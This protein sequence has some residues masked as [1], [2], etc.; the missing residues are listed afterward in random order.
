MRLS[1]DLLG[2]LFPAAAGLATRAKGAAADGTDISDLLASMLAGAAHL[3]HAP[4]RPLAPTVPSLDLTGGPHP[5]SDR[6]GK[7][8]EADEGDAAITV[9]AAAAVLA[10][11]AAPTPA[12]EP[13]IAPASPTRQTGVPEGEGGERLEVLEVLDPLFSAAETTPATAEATPVV[14]NDPA[15][16]DATIATRPDVPALGIESVVKPPA[17]AAALPLPSTIQPPV[18]GTPST[19]PSHASAADVPAPEAAE[20]ALRPAVTRATSGALRSE[21]T[22]GEP[23]DTARFDRPGTA[24]TRPQVNKPDA[25]QVRAASPVSASMSMDARGAGAELERAS[26][27]TAAPTVPST[28]TPDSTPTSDGST[29]VAPVVA[30][31]AGASSGTP[32]QPGGTGAAID[33]PLEWT[34]EPAGAAEL[35]SR[36]VEA[37]NVQLRAGGGTAEIRLTP[38][39][40]GAVHVTVTVDRGT[41]KASVSAETAAGLEVLRAEVGGLRDALEAHGLHLD[42]FEIREDPWADRRFD[43]RQQDEPRRQAPEPPAKRATGSGDFADVFDVVA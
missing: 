3:P 23:A 6:D 18:T 31:H 29:F 26:H 39:F 33:A 41:V 20:A 21:R 28:P 11:M 2:E 32:A 34:A 9:S 15:L 38:A 22:A 30:S 12:A 40:L 42:E 14:P 43:D 19:S 17:R 36:L 27:V 37:M 1:V 13:P 4:H 8:A 25:V 5:L 35:P 24:A 10:L 7:S 16:P